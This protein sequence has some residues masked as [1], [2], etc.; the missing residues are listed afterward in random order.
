MEFNSEKIAIEA[1]NI[2]KRNDIEESVPD[3]IVKAKESEVSFC[4]TQTCP[5]L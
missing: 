3:E 5:K 1:L 4:S 2:F